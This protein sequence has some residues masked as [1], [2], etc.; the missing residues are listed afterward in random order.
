VVGD[1]CFKRLPSQL[2]RS[3]ADYSLTSVRFDTS[4]LNLYKYNFTAPKLD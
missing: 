3:L 4:K 1:T 2:F